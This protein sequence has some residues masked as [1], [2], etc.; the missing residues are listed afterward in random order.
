MLFMKID[1]ICFVIVVQLEVCILKFIYDKREIYLLVVIYLCRY[2]CEIENW[3][4]EF[5]Y[6]KKNF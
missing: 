4:L 1:N 5:I 6:I 2:I 3:F